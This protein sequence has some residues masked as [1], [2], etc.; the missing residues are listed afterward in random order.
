MRDSIE[1][2][3]KMLGGIDLD[4]IH[5]RF[6]GSE[7]LACRALLSWVNDGSHSAHDDLYVSVDEATIDLYLEVFRKIFDH[8]GHIQ[9]YNMMMAGPTAAVAAVTEPSNGGS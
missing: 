2:Y 1:T 7:K 8:Q 4:K 5:D 6:D 3:F 9:H